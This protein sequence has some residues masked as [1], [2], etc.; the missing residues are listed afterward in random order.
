M[1]FFPFHKGRT[2][3]LVRHGKTMRREPGHGKDGDTVIAFYRPQQ[4]DVLVYDPRSNDIAIQ[5]ET[6]GERK[7]YLAVLGR[8]LF[9]DEE[10]FPLA[11]RFTL[12][13]LVEGGAEAL[14]CEDIEGLEQI[15]MVEFRRQWGGAYKEM[16]IR[17]ASDIFAAFGSRGQSIGRGGRLVAAVMKVKV[18]RSPKERSVTIRLPSNA[19][20]ERNEDGALIEAWM[21]KRGFMR[22]PSHKAGNDDRTVLARAG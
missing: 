17:R 11:E 10:H 4:H 7:L 12:D 9:G 3:I 21:A 20:Y 22:T 5:G 8:H 13:P 6:V 2:G 18:R 15:R 16:E 1:T 14:Q 19:K